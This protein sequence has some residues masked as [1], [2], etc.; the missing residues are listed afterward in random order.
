M[1]ELAT[2][3]FDIKYRAGKQNANADALSHLNQEKPEVCDIDEVETLLASTLSTTALPESLREHLLH[4]AVSQRDDPS[5][6]V[7]QLT[8]DP[9]KSTP[10]VQYPPGMLSS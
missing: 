2:F 8:V 10:P 6:V 1:S 7:N 3:S 9:H 4:S 5:A